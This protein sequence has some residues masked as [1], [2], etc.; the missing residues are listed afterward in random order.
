MVE[1][2]TFFMGDRNEFL[3]FF[4]KFAGC[5]EDI[6]LSFGTFMQTVTNL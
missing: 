1:N 4:L 2:S 6:F 3:R 5:V